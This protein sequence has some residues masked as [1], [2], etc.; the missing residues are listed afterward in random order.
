ML[1]DVLGFPHQIEDFYLEINRYKSKLPVY[2]TRL[3]GQGGHL[4]PLFSGLEPSRFLSVGVFEGISVHTSSLRYGRAQ[5]QDK[6]RDE[7]D[8]RQFGQKGSFQQGEE[9][10]HRCD[11][12]WKGL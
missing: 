3:S 2:F 10:S 11:S 4:G 9:G 7:G 5:G 12:N 6:E 1:K 8:V